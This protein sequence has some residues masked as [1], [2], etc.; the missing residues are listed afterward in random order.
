MGALSLEPVRSDGT[1]QIFTFAD[2]SSY[3]ETVE[4][5]EPH[6][7]AARL[8]IAHGAHANHHEVR[9]EEH[10][11]AGVGQS[12]VLAQPGVATSQPKYVRLQPGDN[13]AMT[14][15]ELFD[16]IAKYDTWVYGLLLAYAAAKT[17]PLPMVAGYISFS[18]AIDLSVVLAT[19]FVGTVIGSQLRFL[20]GRRFAPWIYDTFPRIAPWLALGA[21]GGERYGRF[22]LPLY[23]FSKGTYTLIGV[24][25]GAS[26]LLWHRFAL[27]DTLGAFLWTTVWVS[28]G[29]AIAAAGAQVDPR[30]AAYFGLMLLA[31]GILLSAVFGRH[32]K[33]VLLPH[34]TEAL[35]TAR[36]RRHRMA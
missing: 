20:S 12:V 34:A 15:Q 24:G 6:E 1:R 26:P 19:V 2:R 9:F 29:F 4:V 25:S 11:H 36:A 18:G 35:A 27:L 30:W 32:L 13:P 28:V 7:F 5:P 10:T 8:R 22:L 16:W 17:G 3:A 21:S 33:S 14:A 23:R 31:S